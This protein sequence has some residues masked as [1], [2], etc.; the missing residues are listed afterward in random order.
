MGFFIE[1]RK[2]DIGIYERKEEFKEKHDYR[3]YPDPV[4][5]CPSEYKIN[6]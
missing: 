1:D 3:Y 6:R 2:N 4:E 5:I